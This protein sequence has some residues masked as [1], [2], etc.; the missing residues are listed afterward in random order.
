MG[1]I[2]DTNAL[3]G[4]VDGD[5][6]LRAALGHEA[7]L[8]IPFAVL[9]EYLFGVRQSRHRGRYEQWLRTYLPEF[10]LASPGRATAEC[11]AQIRQELKMKGRPIPTNDLWV[12]A[13][14]REAG[15]PVVTRDSHFDAVEGIRVVHW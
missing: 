12:A 9:G 8:V 1:L 2:L 3:S 15:F 13:L 6:R 11:Y 10:E 14:A 7:A 5:V 4:F